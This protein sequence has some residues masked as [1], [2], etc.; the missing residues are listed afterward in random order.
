M[1]RVAQK[2]RTHSKRYRDFKSEYGRLQN[3]RIAAFQEFK[4]DVTTGAYPEPEHCVRIEDAELSVFLKGL[5]A[6]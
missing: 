5:P 4:R 3:E 2:S 1:N 6:C